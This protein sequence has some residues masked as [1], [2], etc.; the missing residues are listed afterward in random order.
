[1]K[2]MLWMTMAGW[3][4]GACLA[5]AVQ[6][7][8]SRPTG[9]H[10]VF[11]R[12]ETIRPYSEN[13]RYWQYRGEPVLLL[14]GSVDDNLF[15]I[16]NLE[17]HLEEIAAAGG[18]YIRNTMSARPDFG[19]EV[20]AYVERDDGTFDLDEWNPEYW[21]R[22]E[23]LLRWTH[24]RDILVQ[25]EVWD[26]FDYSQDNWEASPWRPAN[27]V[28]YSTTASGLANHYPV[29]PWRDKQPFFHSIPGMP[30]YTPALDVVRRRQER[31]M[32]KILAHSL[33]YPNVLYCMNNETSTPPPWGQHWMTF[34]RNQAAEQGRDVFVTDMFDDGWEPRKSAKIRQALDQP[35]TYPFIEISQINSRSFNE[36]HWTRLQWVIRELAVAP[37]PLNNTKIY[38][39]GETNWGSGTPVDGVERFWRN[40]IGGAASCRFHRPGGGIGLNDIARACIRAARALESRIPLWD[41]APRQDL[42]SARET[43]EAYLAAAPGQAYA[44][45]FT[46]GGEV[47]LD[48]SPREGA[49]TVGWINVSTGQWEGE[50][51]LP[52]GDRVTVTVP[53]KGPW[54]AAIVRE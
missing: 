17:A 14:G 6:D 10:P 33:R 1:M 48:L 52:D 38:S 34:I 9:E 54:V 18:N 29:H 24:Q 45:F 23:D 32:A 27:N 30:L 15:Q 12:D 35:E 39:D 47:R 46:D 41:V 36:E 44:L 2:S 8:I 50:G 42:L 25:I 4:L 5:S 7:T 49:F 37:R 19:F 20:Y 3:T 51:S 13:P 26:R 53:G 11:D 16:P 43:D 21:R 31:R 22:F 28:N 40:L